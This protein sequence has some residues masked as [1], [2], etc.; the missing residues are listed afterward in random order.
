MQVSLPSLGWWLVFKSAKD[1][2]D[3]IG[4]V[5]ESYLKPYEAEHIEDY[6]ET[7]SIFNGVEVCSNPNDSLESERTDTPITSSGKESAC[8]TGDDGS[9]QDNATIYRAIADYYTDDKSQVNFPKGARIFVI[10]KDEDG[11]FS[12]N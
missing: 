10:D 2:K 11:E 4:W 12:Y 7:C 1:G 3:Q 6:L 8:V 5:P 9:E